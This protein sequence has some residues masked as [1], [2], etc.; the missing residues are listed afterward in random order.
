M[1]T[2]KDYSGD[3]NGLLTE[4]IEQKVYK[5]GKGLIDGD[6]NQES[7]K[8]LAETFWAPEDGKQYARKDGAWEEVVSGD[9]PVTFT[10]SVNGTTLE[11]TREISGSNICLTGSITVDEFQTLNNPVKNLINDVIPQNFNGKK[12]FKLKRVTMVIDDEP[13]QGGHNGYMELDEVSSYSAGSTV[14]DKTLL[15]LPGDKIGVSR[16]YN[17]DEFFDTSGTPNDGIVDRIEDG[18]T[19]NYLNSSPKDL[20]VSG[21]NMAYLNVDQA[22]SD[23]GISPNDIAYGFTV[24]FVFEGLLL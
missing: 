17:V 3:K 6:K 9:V 15:F 18:T 12:W 1:A 14:T 24:R 21:F 5:N 16:S 23:Y 10:N 7:L 4:G 2:G 19:N 22:E 13:I 20:S 11:I 8:N